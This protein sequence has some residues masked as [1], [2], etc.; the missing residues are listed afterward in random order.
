MKLQHTDCD[1]HPTPA[2][3]IGTPLSGF[4]ALPRTSIPQRFASAPMLLLT[5]QGWHVPR[6]TLENGRDEAKM[7]WASIVIIWPD[8]KNPQTTSIKS[9]VGLLSKQLDT[10]TSACQVI[11]GG[12]FLLRDSQQRKGKKEACVLLVSVCPPKI[13]SRTSTNPHQHSCGCDL[14]EK[15]MV[16]LVNGP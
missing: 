13:P 14:L 16:C 1:W 3:S 11:E 4:A 7:Q 8:R 10:P 2:G 12:V 15:N 6:C 5:F 9:L